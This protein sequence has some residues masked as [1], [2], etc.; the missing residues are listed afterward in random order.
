[1]AL[2]ALV[3]AIVVGVWAA[4]DRAW[5]ILILAIAVALLA[6]TPLLP[7]HLG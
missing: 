6:L 1:M 2:A 4:V 3:L 7:S 5:Q